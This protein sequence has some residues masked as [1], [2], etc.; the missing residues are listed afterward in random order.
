MNKFSTRLP[1]KTESGGTLFSRL[2][3]TR[4][5]STMGDPG[6]TQGKTC[7]GS[8][9]RLMTW[10]FRHFATMRVTLVAT[11][12]LHFGKIQCKDDP[13]AN[14]E[15]SFALTINITEVALCAILGRLAFPNLGSVANIFAVLGDFK[16]TM[17]G[18]SDT[19]YSTPVHMA[20]VILIAGPGPDHTHMNRLVL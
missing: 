12:A 3:P 4:T 8:H 20:L 5:L 7:R 16:R 19:F 1:E 11:K 18:A 2:D 13:M 17:E 15:D 14:F 10:D 6:M 9:G